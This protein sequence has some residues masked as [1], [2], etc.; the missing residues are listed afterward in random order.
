MMLPPDV[1][2]SAMPAGGCREWLSA[3]TSSVIT[4]AVVAAKVR[5]H[6]LAGEHGRRDYRHWRQQSNGPDNDSVQTTEAI[7][8]VKE[9][10]SAFE[11][12]I[13][14]T[15][16]WESPAQVVTQWHLHV[17]ARIRKSPTE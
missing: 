11:P 14:R 2:R 8:T 12:D 5:R 7:E 1:W 16:G 6:G 10:G 15:D 9:T 17:G 13:H 3:L 4:G